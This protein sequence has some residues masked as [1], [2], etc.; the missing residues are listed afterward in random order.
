[1]DLEALIGFEDGGV[2]ADQSAAAALRYCGL[3]GLLEWKETMD[4]HF[5]VEPSAFRFLIAADGGCRAVATADIPAGYPLAVASSLELGPGLAPRGSGDLQAAARSARLRLVELRL[6]TSWL[7][8]DDPAGQ[9][10][11]L[12][13]RSLG[14]YLALMAGLAATAAADA[15]YQ[16]GPYLRSWPSPAS[17]RATHPLYW[18][19]SAA[20]VDLAGTQAGHYIASGRRELDRLAAEVVAPLCSASGVGGDQPAAVALDLRGLEALQLSAAELFKYA[21]VSAES[22]LFGTDDPHFTP[23]VE[24]CNGVPD[25]AA[26]QNC[27]T[28]VK[29]GASVAAMRLTGRADRVST[30]TA[31]E[32]RPIRV[33]D[34]LFL[35]YGEL[36]SASC[37]SKY[38]F[39][40]GDYTVAGAPCGPADTAAIGLGLP[41]KGCLEQLG[42]AQ[43]AALKRVG[44]SAQMLASTAFC[45]ELVSPLPK[46]AALDRRLQLFAELWAAGRAGAAPAGGLDQAAAAAGGLIG[47]LLAWQLEK[48]PGSFEVDAAVVSDP[49]RAGRGAGGGGAGGGG[50]EVGTAGWARGLLIAK[51]RLAER[52]LLRHWAARLA[53]E[54]PACRLG[55]EAAGLGWWAGLARGAAV[56]VAGLVGAPEHNGQRG[57]VVG[58]LAEKGRYVVD[59]GGG[60]GPAAGA[61]SGAGE[62]ASEGAAEGAK[63]RT[64]RV[65][66]ANLLEVEAL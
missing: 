42:P 65:R 5:R 59:I 58:W 17:V 53:A 38:G 60:G 52:N 7:F 11:E 26:E 28:V 23:V 10:A 44:L 22:R 25:G 24:L 33:G 63:G 2:L 6:G 54:L 9:G 18:P 43:H 15:S 66:P 56:E 8:A 64:L 36:G 20:E 48:I 13:E 29:G 30:L 61:I 45:F 62:S 3:R 4:S 37:L 27:A 16:L 40:H 34:E 31:A 21:V 12:V 49:A 47:Q 55:L 19:P 46:R 51:A 32:G 1:M 39:V 50:G 41:S 35:S 14:G 57:V